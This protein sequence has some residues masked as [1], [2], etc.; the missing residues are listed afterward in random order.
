MIWY[1][2]AL[3]LGLAAVVNWLARKYSF[4]IAER[5]F[6]Q[7]VNAE[8]NSRG[9]RNWEVVE[10]NYDGLVFGGGVFRAVLVATLRTEV[11]AAFE[12]LSLYSRGDV[13]GESS[14]HSI[15]INYLGF[16]VLLP[17]GHTVLAA[18]HV[19]RFIDDHAYVKRKLKGLYPSMVGFS[20]V[21]HT[22]SRL[23]N[24]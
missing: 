14:L 24:L 3:T 20:R 15:G 6:L 8:A 17:S 11:E 12:Y 19:P 1:L 18:I 22:L 9:W 5:R 21:D 23:P 2:L 7:F 13:Q 4:G 16:D 10:Q